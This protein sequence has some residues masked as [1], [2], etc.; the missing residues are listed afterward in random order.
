[1]RVDALS[2]ELRPRPMSEAAD[3]GLRLVQMHATD[4]WR[5]CLP[6]F[7]VVFALAASTAELSSWGPPLVV[8]MLKPWMDRS[9]LFVLARA[10]FGEHTRFTD[11]WQAQ[12]QVWWQQLPRTLLLRRFSP[13]R[14][15]T[16][17]IYQLEGQTGAALRS[18][19]SQLVKGHRGAASMM[20]LVFAHT[21]MIL[22]AGGL[23]F[24]YLLLPQGVH[25]DPFKWF[26]QSGSM[27]VT[28]LSFALYASIVCVLEPF[29]VASGFCMYLNRRV[30][31]EA[32]D[33]EQ[34]FRR[35]FAR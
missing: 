2:V 17:P 29:Y 11:L 5:T 9:V 35:V 18:R 26:G 20:H 34:E 28:L 31:L 10:V 8:F 16:Q 4:L 30:E 13:W 7:A 32:W 14:S 24:A 1:M 27:T 22:Y 12:R 23:L 6:V 25:W 33:I 15:F 19:R 3:L 21:E